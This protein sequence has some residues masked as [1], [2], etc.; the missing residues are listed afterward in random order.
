MSNCKTYSA[1]HSSAAGKNWQSQI[2]LLFTLS[3]LTIDTTAAYLAPSKQVGP[4][5]HS[6]KHKSQQ[7]HQLRSGDVHN[8]DFNSEKN[9]W[10]RMAIDR[11][12][13]SITVPPK[14]SNLYNRI[15]SYRQ[16][17]LGRLCNSTMCQLPY[18][19]PPFL[20]VSILYPLCVSMVILL[21]LLPCSAHTAR[22]RLWE[23]M[24]RRG[25]TSL[26]ERSDFLDNVP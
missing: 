24:C 16:V 25:W 10:L 1:L 19:S 9:K 8:Y 15:R 20:Y 5:V 26:E 7:K 21:P 18:V 12:K 17:P 11:A 3:G 23:G 22:R 6:L 2:Q 14:A 13:Q 4:V